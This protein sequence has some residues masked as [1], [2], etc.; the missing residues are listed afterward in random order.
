M[1]GPQ[2]DAGPPSSATEPPTFDQ[3]IGSVALA[4]GRDPAELHPDL[5]VTELCAD[6]LDLYCLH[7]TF[8]EWVPGFRL[9][10]QLD[11]DLATLADA[12]HYLVV[13]SEQR[14]SRGRS[15]DADD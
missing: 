7:I 4:L 5:T 11:L 2:P 8:D 6:S 14:R 9:P 12:H 1:T 10:R 13:R 15:R 3:L